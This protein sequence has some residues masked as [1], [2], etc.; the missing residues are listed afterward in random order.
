LGVG[1]N[2]LVVVG[3]VCALALSVAGA[4]T[5]AS[6]PPPFHQCPALGA[7]TSCALLIY[8]TSSGTVGVLGDP[9]Q[10]PFDGIEDTLIGVQNDSNAPIAS[11]PVASTNGKDLFGFD[12]DGLCTFLANAGCPFGPTGYEGPGVSFSGISA[13]TTSGTVNFSP[14]IPAHGG[15][16]YFSL[17][18]ALA[19]VPPFDLA[20]GTPKPANRYVA[21]GDSVP[22]GHGLS[23]PYPQSK[24]G[25]NGVGQPPAAAAYPG[26]VRDDLHLTM[27]IRPTN[28][29]L[30]KDDMA[31][32]GAPMS[33]N[34]RGD[35]N[36]QCSNFTKSVSVEGDELAY[37]DI[38]DSPAQLVTI[39][40]GADDI[41]FADCLKADLLSPFGARCVQ[42]GKVTTDVS[43]RLKNLHGALLSLIYFLSR[44]QSAAHIAVLNYYQAIPSLRDFDPRS[45]QPNGN[46]DLICTLLAGNL[47]QTRNDAVVVQ[48]ALNNEIA[49]AVTEAKNNGITN[50]QLVDISHL[51]DHHEM[52][53]GKPAL[54]S[55]EP[56]SHF[57]FFFDTNSQTFDL[58]DLEDHVWRA[59]HPNSFGQRD[60]ANAVEH[61]L[62]GVL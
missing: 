26:L 34:N 37:S 28:C 52:C 17:E 9:S 51:E 16:A 42:N 49:S 29:T 11:I 56:M 36:N 21:F 59:A 13:D 18:E 33:N 30:E 23:N 6:P 62:A 55:G 31:F 45:A 2:L 32:S 47:S 35:G 50:V 22:Y 39:Q 27:D 10:A 25:S 14:P 5:S 24:P 46:I 58:P 3:A 57:R 43:N 1:R 61:A 53:T 44:S 7:D 60:I 54:F 41:Q 20:P 12:G 4:A 8:I 19:T 40:A 48:Q 38:V 15:H